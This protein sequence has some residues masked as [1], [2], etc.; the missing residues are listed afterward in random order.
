[1]EMKDEEIVKSYKEAK[2][3]RHQI[4]ILAEL[5]ACSVDYIKKILKA[6]GVDL[7]GGNYRAKKPIVAVTEIKVAAPE[8]P[9]SNSEPVP[10]VLVEAAAFGIEHINL[11][12]ESMEKELEDL[13]NRIKDLKAKKVEICYA[14][15]RVTQETSK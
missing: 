5:N 15:E 9:V 8:K 12:L 10:N 11:E 14:I 1:M 4:E 13:T 7:R 6:N 3:K 2:N